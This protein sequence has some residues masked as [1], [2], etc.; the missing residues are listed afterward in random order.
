MR[1]LQEENKHSCFELCDNGYSCSWILA[2]TYSSLILQRLAQLTP[3]IKVQAFLATST[4][5]R[6]HYAEDEEGA[7][8]DA[9]GS[10]INLRISHRNLY[11][12]RAYENTPKRLSVFRDRRGE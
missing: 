8:G 6:S 5:S 4:F 7:E 2:Q 11:Y 12:S 1:D 10:K 3:T 9:L